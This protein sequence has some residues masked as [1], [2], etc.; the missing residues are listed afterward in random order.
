MKTNHISNLSKS[1]LALALLALVAGKLAA[2]I[3]TAS[4]Q[5]APHASIPGESTSS[6]GES[7]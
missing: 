4:E 1:L 6:G 5:Q 2:Q 7:F 3:N